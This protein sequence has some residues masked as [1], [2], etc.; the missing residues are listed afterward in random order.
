MS[1]RRRIGVL[2]I[3]LCTGLGSACSSAPAGPSLPSLLGEGRPVLFIGNSLTYWNDLPLIVQALADSAGGESLA[4]MVVAFPDYSLEDHRAEGTAL[5]A[6]ARGDWAVVVLQQGPSSLPENRV[7]LRASVA[8]LS[9]EIRGVSATPALYSVWPSASRREDFDRAIESYAL[10]A[11]DVNGK[12]L[13]VA[14]AWLAAWRRDSELALYSPDGLHPSAA[15]SYLAA[16][17]MY[18]AL[19]ER[20]PVGL[21]AKVRVASGVE[22][23]VTPEAAAV[24]QAAAAEVL[25]R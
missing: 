3:L 21:P 5:R 7:Q 14:A 22:R 11:Q 10:A 18:G 4:V 2:A 6:I 24:L 8:A 12:L 17:V 23:G 1:V 25:G 13:P 19:F 9:A 16:L 15:G 20:S